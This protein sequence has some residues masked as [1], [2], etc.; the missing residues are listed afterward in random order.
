MNKKKKIFFNN[1]IIFVL[2]LLY[3][4]SYT[5][6]LVVYEILNIYTR[7]DEIELSQYININENNNGSVHEL[8]GIC[9]YIKIEK[10]LTH[11][12]PW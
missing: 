4:L 10:L 6:L 8:G 9:P 2:N 12:M 11:S 1:F 7:K 5:T 3:M